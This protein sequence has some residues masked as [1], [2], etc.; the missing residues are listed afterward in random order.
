MHGSRAASFS[1]EAIQAGGSFT[2]TTRRPR[3][4]KIN[5]VLGIQAI[6][7]GPQAFSQFVHLEKVPIRLGGNGKPAGHANACG[8]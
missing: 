4:D 1:S 8:H 2:V 7:Y 5:E 6:H 3:S